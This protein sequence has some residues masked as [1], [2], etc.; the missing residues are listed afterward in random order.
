MK[1]KLLFRT[2]QNC[3]NA[4][5][6][7]LI[8]FFMTISSFGQSNGFTFDCLDGGG[9][10]VATITFSGPSQ[11]N[12]NGYPY[13]TSGVDNIPNS[14]DNYLLFVQAVEEPTNSGNFVDRWEVHLAIPNVSFPDTDPPTGVSFGALFFYS[15]VIP[16]TL[17]CDNDDA[18]WSN[19][20]GCASVRVECLDPDN[21]NDTYP[22]SIDCDDN[23][24]TVNPG[25]T[26]IPYDGKD[27]DCDPATL[28]D[29]LDEDG[30]VI[31][32][33][34]NDGNAAINPDATEVCD[35]I[36]NNC[37]FGVDEGLTFITYYVD[38]DGD[39]FGD[40]ADAGADFCSDPGIGYSLNNDDC[41][42]TLVGIN[43]DATEIPD[44]GIDQ[45]CDGVD[46]TTTT[47]DF[48]VVG[49]KKVDLY[50]NNTVSGNVGATKSD[51]KV[52]LQYMSTVSGSVE[53]S[54]IV[55]DNTSSAGSTILTPAV[56]NLPPFIFNNVSKNSNLN[57]TI[58]PGQT[59]TLNGQIY[60]RVKVRHGGTAI[61]TNSN[62]YLKRLKTF[63]N[64]IVDFQSTE[65]CT[66]LYINKKVRMKD[67]TSFNSSGTN[68][69]MYVDD[70]VD[71]DEG[72]DVTAYIYANKYIDVKGQNDNRTNM[73]GFFSGKKVFGE[74]NVS[75]TGQA[76]YVPCDIVEPD[77]TENGDCDCK[78]GMVSLTFAYNG[79]YASL[80]TTNSGYLIDNYDG[81]YTV[82]N[83][84][85]KLATNLEISDGDLDLDDDNDD[86][87][88]D[89]DISSSSFATINTSCSEEIIDVTYDSVFTVVSHTD[90]IGN[91]CESN[92]SYRTSV[93]NN[94]QT[95]RSFSGFEVRVWPNPSQNNFNV[96]VTTIDDLNDI[97]IQ[98]IDITGKRI[99]ADTI[100]WNNEYEFGDRLQ[101]GIYFVKITQ[102][103]TSEVIKIIKR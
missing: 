55:I 94:V 82:F 60:R 44:D 96:K 89:D 64:A 18:S 42:D 67:N 15:N 71:I 10:S 35:G 97:N 52:K 75:W 2:I 58:E 34:C 53:A 8:I 48:V 38:A 62:V 6:T 86:D 31:A 25:A 49:L 19:V 32:N 33:D 74:E 103:N 41:D 46:D 39:G 77:E 88:D 70:K 21:D 29:D 68:V 102:N 23:D 3:K 4:I 30:F 87:G 40:E 59:I 101:S 98:V 90:N 13:W 45:D 11:G 92:I 7:L 61:F 12:V 36:D 43:P 69:T 9:N 72:S 16:G 66:N 51:G 37:V 1:T 95:V 26:E 57:V 54:E 81:T 83:D 80:L 28:D 47:N 73:T 85:D 56:V 79:L 17:V 63:D 50:D 99:H 20:V 65:G 93:V 84:G 78:D 24:A 27:N 76:G 91:V 100:K 5:F 14:T 22:A